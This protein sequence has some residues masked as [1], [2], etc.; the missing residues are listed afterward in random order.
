MRNWFLDLFLF[1]L[2]FYKVS[3]G[4]RFIMVTQVVMVYE[5]GGVVFFLIELEFSSF[6]KF[7]DLFTDLV[8]WPSS[9][10]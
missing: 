4:R 1:I 7:M 2:F 10:V 8:G 9:L 6:T 5:F 3:V